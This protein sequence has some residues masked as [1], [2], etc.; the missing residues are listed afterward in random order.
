MIV[1]LF[2]SVCLLLAVVTV[3][4]FAPTEGRAQSI[5]ELGILDRQ[6]VEH[7][8][9]GEYARA[10]EVGRRALA[11][12]ERR[13]GSNHAD[14]AKILSKL[15]HLYVLQGRLEDAEQHFKRALAIRTKVQGASHTSV[16]SLLKDL[17]NLHFEQGRF[18]DAERLLKR[19][20]AIFETAHGP[21][22]FTVARLL[23]DL[24]E[25]YRAQGRYVAAKP[26]FERSL[27][28]AE[29]ALGPNHMTVAEILSGLAGLKLDLGRYADAEP[30]YKRALAIREKIGGSEHYATANSLNNLALLY[31]RQGRD[32]D[33][34]RLYKRA[35]AI[36][37]KL[38]GPKHWSVA[39][40][41]NNLAELYYRQDRFTDAEPLYKRSI[42][43]SEKV[44][45]PDHPNLATML[46]NL[47]FLY[48]V[49]KRYAE[50]ELLYKRSLKIREKVLGPNHRDVASSLYG[51]AHLYS[52]QRRFP[53]AQRYYK[54][55]YA[56]SQEVLGPEHPETVNKLYSLGLLDSFYQYKSRA[57]DRVSRAAAIKA[58]RI[59][60]GTVQPRGAAGETQEDTSYFRSEV[61]MAWRLA[62]DKRTRR[63]ELARASFGAAQWAGRTSAAAALGQMAARLGTGDTE[64]A[65]RVRQRQD[66]AT[67]WQSLDK[68]LI[69]ALSLP[70]DKRDQ[71]KIDDLRASI[72]KVETQI[73]DLRKTLEKEAP[74]FAELANPRPLTIEQTQKLLGPDEALVLYLVDDKR[75]FVWAVTRDKVEW[76]LI[77][78][79]KKY[80]EREISA[81]RRSLDP[82][83]LL[84]GE[85]SPD[86]VCRGFERQ[87]QRCKGEDADLQRAHRLYTDLI[88]PVAKAINSKRHLIIVP[89]GPLTG[90]PF[91]MLLTAPPP[92]EGKPADRLKKAQWL[93]RRHA[94]T[95]LPSVSSLKALRVL[96]RKGQAKRPFIGF[97][98]P[99]F[100]KPDDKTQSQG[101]VRTVQATRGYATYFRGKLADVDSLSGRIPP[102]PDTAV[103]LRTVGQLFKARKSEVVLGR[104]AS[105]SFVKKLSKDGKL[106][107]Y[108]IV[109]FATH[110]LIAGEI[111][112]LGEPA[113]ALSLPNAA[114]RQ[115]DGLL[116]ASE[117]AQL[118]LNADWVVLSACNTAAGG[119][120]GAEAFSGLARAFFYSGARALLVSHWPVISE[121]AVKLTTGAFSA[122]TKD[123]TIGRAEALRRSMLA[124]IDEGAPYQRH[125]AYWAPF[126]VVGEG[127]REANS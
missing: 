106:G 99:E 82:R 71:K 21:S 127:G 110:G 34:E 6:L 16:G 11:L 44:L 56:I 57:Y 68:K 107:D 3:P 4:G 2:S 17:A 45:R 47:A 74:E 85:S 5:N 81:L 109:H 40:M 24:A 126:A 72:T 101:A 1:R 14:V 42:A 61:H 9:S 58:A 79:K 64:L 103:E 60:N 67:R 98:N 87:D 20:L 75:S 10:L 121:A 27:A 31:S 89:S 118:K 12:T 125:P 29:K 55:S 117:V 104:Q 62:I 112:G 26:L 7:Y 25:V 95:V 114:T 46:H 8:R 97:G 92:S 120:P 102:L 32:A 83:L 80:I 123:P 105:E 124:L 86:Q 93:I 100:L 49:Q 53:E 18:L 108:R 63:P 33:A 119:K 91:H 13:F 70:S 36:K 94:V 84:A 51:I 59:L 35:I 69:E 22:H 28:T 88:D 77:F 19:S 65:R 54:R 43:I 96:A 113:L 50:A 90:L 37:E 76:R 48:R 73:A 30:L 111:K 78:E 15:A 41:L 23:R 116:T 52:A 66:L 39:G 122:L 38:Y 115:D